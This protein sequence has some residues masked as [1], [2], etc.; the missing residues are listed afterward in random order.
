[1]LG[2]SVCTPSPVLDFQPCD[3]DT[4]YKRAWLELSPQMREDSLGLHDSGGYMMAD[5]VVGVF[6]HV[7]GDVFHGV[8][9]E[10]KEEEEEEEEAIEAEYIGIQ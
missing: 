2:S 1:M 4:L 5:L 6:R 3:L 9:E 7:F 10:E 8:G